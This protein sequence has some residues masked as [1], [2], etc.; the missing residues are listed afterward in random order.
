ME[1]DTLK[2]FISAARDLGYEVTNDETF[3]KEQQDRVFDWA[4]GIHN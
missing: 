3:L 2:V 4:R 1:P